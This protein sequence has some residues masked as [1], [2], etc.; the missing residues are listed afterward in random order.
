MLHECDDRDVDCSEDDLKLPVDRQQEILS[1]STESKDNV[2]ADVEISQTV[3]CSPSGNS[4]VWGT[5]D[6]DAPGG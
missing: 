6:S 3:E 5:E 4:M 2:E 1:I